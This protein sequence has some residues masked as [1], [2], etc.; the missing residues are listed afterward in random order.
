MTNSCNVQLDKIYYDFMYMH[1]EFSFCV[2][3]TFDFNE[4]DL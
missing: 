4:V 2:K 3:T 1:F